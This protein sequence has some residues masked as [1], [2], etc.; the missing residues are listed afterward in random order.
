VA[1]PFETDWTRIARLIV[2]RSLRLEPGERVL[3]HADPTYFP[4]LTEA[5]RVEIARAGA[6]ELAVHMLHPPG[7]ER[8][9]R[10][11]RRREE[12]SL[13]ALE[14]RAVA[15]LFALADVYIWLPTSWGYNV[16]QTEKVLE[17][18]RG[19]SIH[20]HW[21]MDVGMD[22]GLFRRLSALYDAALD[23]D[24]A[25]LAAHQQRVVAALRDRVVEITDDR[26]TRLRF[27]L[28]GAHFH[29]GNGDASRAFIDGYA[30]PGSARDREVELPAGAVRTV[31]IADTEGVL[32]TPPEVFAGRP[33]GQLRLEFAGNRIVRIQAEHGDA[34]VQ[35]IW[36][37][38]TGDRDRFGEFNLGVNPRLAVVPGVPYLPY[39]GYGAGVVRVSV[40]DNAES[41]GPCRSSYHQWLF[42][43]DATVTADGRRI[44]DRGTLVLP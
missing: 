24:Y 41:G 1:P 6:V 16:G 40:G 18:W 5:V 15:D 28:P 42:L 12:P 11:L 17:T 26:G 21:I 2:H 32:V 35:A 7:L 9:R 4:A 38:E 27:A 29:L 22:A 3:I 14:D 37:T 31:D 33:V 36:R 39:Y 20:F 30:R 10:E 19:R 43:T 13:R 25:A 8:V 44:V 23:V 34:Q